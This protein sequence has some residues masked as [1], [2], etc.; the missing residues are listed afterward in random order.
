MSI[1]DLRRHQGHHSAKFSGDKPLYDIIV[2]DN[3]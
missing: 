1:G 2:I 3:R